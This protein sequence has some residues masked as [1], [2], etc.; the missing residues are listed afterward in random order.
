M[1]RL[2]VLATAREVTSEALFGSVV[3]LYTH[4]GIIT[5]EGD[6]P[7]FEETMGGAFTAAGFE[8]TKSGERPPT[9]PHMLSRV[10]ARMIG[11]ESP[12]PRVGMQGGGWW[13]YSN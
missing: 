10:H 12:I 6:V 1:L 2:S 5:L 4:I 11:S 3:K 7:T 13:A 9:P 8:V